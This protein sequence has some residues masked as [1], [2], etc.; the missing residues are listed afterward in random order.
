MSEPPAGAVYSPRVKAIVT[1]STLIST[2][3][4]SI[5]FF[6]TLG[7]L[8]SANTDK[9]IF[10]GPEPVNIPL[11]KPSLPELNLH[12]LTPENSAVRTNISRIFPSAAEPL[13]ESAWVLLDNLTY[14]Q[15]Y[16]FRV[17]WAAS[18]PTSFTLD[19]YE[20]NAVWQTP[21]LV[22]SLATYAYSRMPEPSSNG[23]LPHSKSALKERDASVLLV[24]I[25]AAADY[26]TH[27]KALMLNPPPVLVDLILDPY[28][29]N[30]V[31]RS[32]LPTA[33]FLVVVGVVT[34]FMAQWIVRQLQAVRDT[35]DRVVEKKKKS[36]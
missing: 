1:H 30:V 26:F 10:L 12:A 36:N 21:E 3:L 22:Q 13:G 7:V 4:I 29:L 20:L 11:T 28:V 23:E 25:Q 24:H 35:D 34:W 27:H 32:L 5:L 2:A 18:E 9:L 19:V 14:G 8:V 16:E 15:R 17:C 31:P 33:G 6:L